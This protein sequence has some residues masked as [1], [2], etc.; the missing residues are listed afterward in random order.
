MRTGLFLYLGFCLGTCE[1]DK[2]PVT[3]VKTGLGQQSLPV[4]QNIRDL[5]VSGPQW[6]ALE[7]IYVASIEQ[8][9][10]VIRDLFIQGLS[11]FQKVPEADLLSYFQ[12]SGKLPIL[13]RP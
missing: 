3:G 12:I 8:L 1:A 6:Y 5:E 4:R 9:M 2:I 11:L 13:T 7:K 10:N